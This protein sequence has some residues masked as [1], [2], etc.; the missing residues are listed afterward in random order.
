MNKLIE[1]LSN[2]AT[3][4]AN[5]RAGNSIEWLNLYTERLTQ[6]TIKECIEVAECMGYEY[7]DVYDNK[8]SRNVCF[9]VR[10]SIKQLIED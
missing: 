4:H 2:K 3:V 1:E 7:G 10:D 6:L 9:N 8:H 5:A